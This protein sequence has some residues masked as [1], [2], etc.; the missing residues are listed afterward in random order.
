M[1]ADTR[2]Q[3]HT[4][5][6]LLPL[7]HASR[8]LHDQKSAHHIN[9]EQLSERLSRVVNSIYLA[10]DTSTCHHTSERETKSISCACNGFRDVLGIRD[11]DWEVRELCSVCLCYVLVFFYVGW[12]DSRRRWVARTE[13]Y[14]FEGLLEGPDIT[15]RPLTR[16]WMSRLLSPRRLGLRSLNRSA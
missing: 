5:I 14:G 6:A 9:V 8:S 4:P 1:A 15:R 16:E 2:N 11:V 3:Y 13:M 7:H 12:S 10:R